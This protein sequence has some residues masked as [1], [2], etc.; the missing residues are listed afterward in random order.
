MRTL[1][2]LAAITGVVVAIV[3]LALLL[4]FG[5]WLGHKIGDFLGM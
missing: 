2:V 3:L 1:Y 4:K 5:Y